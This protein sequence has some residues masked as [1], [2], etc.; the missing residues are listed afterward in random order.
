MGLIMGALAAATA[1]AATYNV[2]R[3]YKAR[4]PVTMTAL[5]IV[6]LDDALALIIYG[7][8]SA[9][10][11]SLAIHES[12]SLVKA[13]GFPLLEILG[14]ACVGAVGG[15][16]LHRI[17]L[18]ASDKERILPYTIGIIILVVGFSLFLQIDPILASMV[19]GTVA[20]NLQSKSPGGREMFDLVKKF[21]VPIFVLFFVLVG[22]QLDAR[23]LMKTGVLI[24]AL[25]YI[26][27]RSIGKVAGATI[28]G[29]L[30]KARETVTKYTGFCLFDQA[31]VAVGLSIAVYN[32]FSVLGPEPKA[33]GLVIINVITATT[34]LLQLVAPPMIKMGIKKS[35]EMYRDVTEED[36]IQTHKVEDVMDADFLVIRE[37][38]NLHQIIDIMKKSDADNFPV[39][40]MG[41]KFMGITTLGEIRDTFYEEQ[42][43]QLILAG[44]IVRE[45]DTVV[46]LGQDLKEAMAIFRTRKTDYIPV[47]E[48]AET[49]KLVGQLEYKKLMDFITKEVIFRQQELETE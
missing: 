33:V 32:S 3:E 25:V 47:L 17:V 21:S 19:L 43:D 41:D 24:L 35:D 48:N 31:G 30:S 39:V 13:V 20:A 36:I 29:K 46:Y 38:N 15:Y 23:I 5:S 7:F 18:R 22:A 2:L 8:A 42:M 28:G 14:S 40:S 4:G 12:V 34:F 6:A 16:I 9:F 49:R 26:I 45:I 10:A 37:N 27:S 1:P 44:D 11:R